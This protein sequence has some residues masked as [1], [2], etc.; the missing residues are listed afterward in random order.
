MKNSFLFCILSFAIFFIC[1]CQKT[2]Q[3]IANEKLIV[4]KWAT[5]KCNNVFG[6]D[7][8]VFNFSS[9]KT[10]SSSFHGETNAFTWGIK[11]NFLNTFYKTG[12]RGYIIG[13]DQ[14]NSQGVYKI[15]SIQSTTMELV[16]DDYDGSQIT[17][18]FHKIK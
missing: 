10:G 7:S 17:L 9:D 8:A 3:D 4:G 16:Q 15:N 14:Y 6:C 5:T 12:P 1:S 13:N 18:D 2:D 11:N